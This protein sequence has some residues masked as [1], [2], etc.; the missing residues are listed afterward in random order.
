MALHRLRTLVIC[1]VSSEANEQNMKPVQTACFM[2]L[3]FSHTLTANAFS[4]VF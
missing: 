1:T 4:D 3:H 2:F